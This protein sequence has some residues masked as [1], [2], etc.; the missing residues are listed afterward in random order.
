MDGIALAAGQFTSFRKYHKLGEDGAAWFGMVDIT[1]APFKVITHPEYFRRAL[2]F[3]NASKGG[4]R[5][6]K[7]GTIT[8]FGYRAGDLVQAEKVGKVYRGWIGGF[9]KVNKVVSV[10]DHNWHRIGQFSVGKVQLIRR[11]T[12]LCV[13]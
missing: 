6:R 12:K 13:A 8:P 5:K 1:P 4:T 7:G 9:S 2:H 11:S 10:Y 3:D